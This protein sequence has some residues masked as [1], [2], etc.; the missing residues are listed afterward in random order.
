MFQLIKLQTTVKC[1]PIF[2]VM[3]NSGHK[4]RRETET[5]AVLSVPVHSSGH[6]LLLQLCFLLKHRL[7]GEWVLSGAV[8]EEHTLMSTLMY[9]LM[10]T[11]PLRVNITSFFQE[12]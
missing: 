5:R 10:S 1:C 8:S 11:A 12:P 7:Q 3:P 9:W 2:T 6:T 4:H